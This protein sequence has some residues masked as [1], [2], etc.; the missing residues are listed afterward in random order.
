MSYIITGA[1]LLTYN[2][3]NVFL[4][5][6]FRLNSIKNYTVE[7][8]FLQQ[9]NAQGVSGNIALESGL[10]RSLNEREDIIVNGLNLGP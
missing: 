4:S 10:V 7:G 8:F 3:Q 5:D 6:A 9:T 1:R 2:H